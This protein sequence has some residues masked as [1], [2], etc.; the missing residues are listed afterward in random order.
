MKCSLKVGQPNRQ[1]R[2]IGAYTADDPRG[3][4]GHAKKGE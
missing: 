3:V 2:V 1:S 4:D